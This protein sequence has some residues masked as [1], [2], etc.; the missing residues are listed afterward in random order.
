[1]NT[2]RII[3]YAGSPEVSGSLSFT[4]ADKIADCYADAVLWASQNGIVKGYNDG[5]FGP[6]RPL[7]RAEMSAIIARYCQM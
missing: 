1:M 7:T 2:T 4:D 3:C 5:S 6:N